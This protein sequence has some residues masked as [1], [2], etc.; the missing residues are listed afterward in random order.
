[1]PVRFIYVFYS[2]SAERDVRGFMGGCRS[3]SSDLKRP[4]SGQSRDGG[5]ILRLSYGN[6]K[7]EMALTGDNRPSSDR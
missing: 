7:L 1:M 3:T 4:R 2:R 5:A 6:S